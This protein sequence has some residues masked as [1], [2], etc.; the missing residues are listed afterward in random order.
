VSASQD[1]LFDYLKELRLG[2]GALL[3]QGAGF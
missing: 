1:L 3:E 2:D